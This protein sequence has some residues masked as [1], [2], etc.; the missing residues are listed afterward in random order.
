MESTVTVTLHVRTSLRLRAQNCAGE[1][2]A[3]AC[4]WP[5]SAIFKFKASAWPS[6]S[7]RDHLGSW[8]G[9]AQAAARAVGVSLSA[10]SLTRS[11]PAVASASDPGPA[12]ELQV[13][14]ELCP[15]TRPGPALVALAVGPG[16]CAS[17]IAG[18]PGA[19]KSKCGVGGGSLASRMSHVRHTQHTSAS[20]SAG[21]F[22][23]GRV[24]GRTTRKQ[25]QCQEQVD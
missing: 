8:R 17:G 9:P 1:S 22:A 24:G 4:Q 3:R 11:A 23:G 6:E 12:P 14:S 2:S 15:R 7:P 21:S 20:L 5:G 19:E 16:S 25:E 18:A 10:G 13:A